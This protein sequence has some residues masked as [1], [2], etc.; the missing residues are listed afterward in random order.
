MTTRGLRRV[1]ARVENRDKR[2]IIE[3]VRN[4]QPHLEADGP[5]PWWIFGVAGALVLAMVLFALGGP[6]KAFSNVFP[7]GAD[8]VGHN[9]WLTE[10]AARIANGHLPLGWTSAHSDGAAFGY[11]YFPLPALV[12]TLFQTVLPAAVA[13]KC[14]LLLA[15]LVIPFGTV[16]FTAGLGCTR[17]FQ[18]MA[19]VSS[20]ALLLCAQYVKSGSGFTI[21]GGTIFTTYIG[22]FSYAFALGLGLWLTGEIARICRGHGHWWLAGIL[23]AATAMSHAQLVL[24]MMIPVGVVCAFYARTGAAAKRLLGAGALGAALAAW[25]WLPALSLYNEALGDTKALINDPFKWLFAPPMLVLVVVSIAGLSWGVVRNLTGARVVATIAFLSAIVIA[26]PVQFF[27]T[28]RSAPLATAMIA[29]GIAYGLEALFQVWFVPLPRRIL[30]TTGGASVIAVL[31]AFVLA[32]GLAFSAPESRGRQLKVDRR[33]VTG[34]RAVPGAN[35]MM[36]LI[37]KLNELPAGGAIVETPPNTDDTTEIDAW[38]TELPR[39]TNGKISTPVSLYPEGSIS[40]PA[41]EYLYSNLSSKPHTSTEWAPRPTGSD[42]ATG[43]KQAQTFGVRYY[44]A[45]TPTL[46]DSAKAAPGVTEVATVGEAPLKYAIFSMDTPLVATG[47]TF[48]RVSEMS[49]RA[50]VLS[51]IAYLKSIKNDPNAPVSVEK[52]PN[53]YSGT[54]QK[55]DITDVSVTDTRIRFTV[56]TPNVPVIVRTSY[57]ERW[58]ATGAKGPYRTSPNVMTVVP[59]QNTVTLRF[60]P[61]ITQRIGWWITVGAIVML[62]ALAGAALVGRVRRRNRPTDTAPAGED[63]TIAETIGDEIASIDGFESSED[64]PAPGTHSLFKRRR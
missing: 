24:L 12:F 4:N 6:A 55:V 63:T 25:W 29:L 9:W 57:S 48:N 23:V 34:M 42:V 47:A 11:F 43:L 28:G 58:K 39:W 16:Q 35:S 38:Y 26:L 49:K 50:W 5:A 64:N 40:T 10:F 37:N 31:L 52:L 53:E 33:A 2:R 18:A 62:L 60:V 59:T 17:R 22:E 54:A 7:Y 15:V 32:C 36:A 8:Q 27:G 61:P 3:R 51:S 44:I 14:T 19:M 46:V 1:D 41:I 45:A 30:G 21:A 20:L 13:I 56:A